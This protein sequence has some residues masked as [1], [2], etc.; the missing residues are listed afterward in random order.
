MSFKLKV[1]DLVSVQPWDCEGIEKPWGWLP[2]DPPPKKTER[3]SKLKKFNKVKIT[4]NSTGIVIEVDHLGVD[5][6]DEHY[7]LLVEGK[8]LSVPIRFIH[9]L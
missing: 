2:N 3:G 5:D 7:Q 1:N 9:K 6:Y 8:A 4:P